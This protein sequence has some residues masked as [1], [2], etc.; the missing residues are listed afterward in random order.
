MQDYDIIDCISEVSIL[1]QFLCGQCAQSNQLSLEDRMALAL[2]IKRGYPYMCSQCSQTFLY[3][4]IS[5]PVEVGT[6]VLEEPNNSVSVAVSTPTLENNKNEETP[7]KSE[8]GN[9][10]QLDLFLL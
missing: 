1:Q 7:R 6:E 5:A 3:S 8:A 4:L 9:V 10:E 2:Q